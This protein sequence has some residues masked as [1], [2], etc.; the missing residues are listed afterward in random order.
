MLDRSPYLFIRATM[1]ALRAELETALARISGLALNE[2]KAALAN[3]LE[4]A[5]RVGENGQATI[6]LKADLEQLQSELQAE[7]GRALELQ[8]RLTQAEEHV[9]VLKATPPPPPPPAYDEREART[10]GRREAQS[11]LA[12]HLMKSAEDLTSL[13]TEL[14]VSLEHNTRLETEL[15]GLKELIGKQ[16]N[17]S[18]TKGLGLQNVVKE[19]LQNAFD[20][21]FEIADT[22]SQPGQLD[23][24]LVRVCSD[25]AKELRI[26]IECKDWDRTFLPPSEM[27]TFDTN[28]KRLTA[29]SDNSR[30]HGAIL[31]TS[32]ALRSEDGKHV[33]ERRINNVPVI[34]IGYKSFGDLIYAVWSIYLEYER[35]WGGE[36]GKEKKE[37]EEEVADPGVRGLI[38]RSVG[39]VAALTKEMNEISARIDEVKR[40]QCVT[41]LKALRDHL[42]R[43]HADS[44]KVV[45]G[46]VPQSTV[47]I[48]PCHIQMGR[49]KARKSQYTDD[50]ASRKRKEAPSESRKP[51][52]KSKTIEEALKSLEHVR[53]SPYMH[54]SP[55]GRVREDK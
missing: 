17:T 35:Q 8:S 13:R 51:A 38:S 2:S 33:R 24:R 55:P 39:M 46:L 6:A 19:R 21:V 43:T 28:V 45:S 31:F 42:E 7:R 36:N 37:K 4:R 53:S 27:A 50:G 9:S 23:I 3:A 16:R 22:S 18:N 15:N 47:D 10:A 40:Q 14:R 49:G 20:G 30:I 29:T 26:G 54:K 52:K 34:E 5:V 32:T 12:Q 11:E 41:E 1:E 25:P 48:L 44:R